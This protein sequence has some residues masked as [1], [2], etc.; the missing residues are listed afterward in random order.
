MFFLLINIF[1]IPSA[2][3]KIQM[4]LD[5]LYNVITGTKDFAELLGKKYL[6]DFG[7]EKLIL[8][9][10]YGLFIGIFEL[11]KI[12]EVIMNRFHIF[13]VFYKRYFLFSNE[14]HW[15][16]NE[17]DIFE[18]GYYYACMITF[19]TVIMIFSSTVP[20]IIVGGLYY[21]IIKHLIDSINILTVYRREMDSNGDLVNSILHR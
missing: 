15:R 12:T 9:V 20:L 5:T 6:T 10:S 14:N 8:I 18:Y 16:R 4:I 13:F 21:F 11:N 2:T 1:L 3:G 17:K 7:Y 19:L